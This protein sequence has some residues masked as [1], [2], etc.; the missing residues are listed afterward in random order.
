MSTT[1]TYTEENTTG[2]LFLTNEKGAFVYAFGKHEFMNV[3]PWTALPTVL[4]LCVASVIGTG[5]N[6]LTILAII[7]CRKIR[8]E[9]SMF[10]ANLAIA[11]LYVTVV[12][13]PMSIIG[14]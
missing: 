1:L 10:L 7:T 12:A 6:V 5:G 13:D 3:N 2:L 8:N 14:E 11:D 9:E 4:L